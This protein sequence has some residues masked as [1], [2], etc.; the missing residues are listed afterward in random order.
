MATARAIAEANYAQRK[1]LDDALA[2]QE[3]AVAL[4]SAHGVVLP[5][6]TSLVQFRDH[7]KTKCNA[8]GLNPTN[9]N[10]VH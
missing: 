9:F 2:G 3:G 10:D 1:A 4:A 5:N 8:L 7:V 6:I